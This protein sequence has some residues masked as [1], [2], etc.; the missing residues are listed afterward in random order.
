M[1][2]KDRTLTIAA[3]RNMTDIVPLAYDL[4]KAKGGIIT[5]SSLY[6]GM[7]RAYTGGNIGPV[8]NNIT[9]IW[10]SGEITQEELDVVKWLCFENNA[11]IKCVSHPIQ[12]CVVNKSGEPRNLG[13]AV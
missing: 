13:C 5:P 2:V 1:V 9:K 8:S 7:A 3:K 11:V 4:K 10:N 12:Q 6:E